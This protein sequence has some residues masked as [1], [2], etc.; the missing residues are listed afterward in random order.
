M[1]IPVIDSDL[2]LSD[3]LPDSPQFTNSAVARCV[4]AFRQAMDA[5]RRKSADNYHAHK[6]ASMAYRRTMPPLTSRQNITDFISCVTYGL[7]I[8]TVEEEAGRLLYAAQIAL[9][10]FP[11]EGS[12]GPKTNRK[13]QDPLPTPPVL[14]SAQQNT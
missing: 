5:A 11:A 10:A 6:V 2:V 1:M 4:E 13:P 8:G 7:L 14:A 12:A 3:V 9:R